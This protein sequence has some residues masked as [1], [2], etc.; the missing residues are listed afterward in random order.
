MSNTNPIG[1]LVNNYLMMMALPLG[2]WFVAEYLLRCA[3]MRNIYLSFVTTPLMVV[4]PIALWYIL[5][6]LR[7]QILDDKI[8]W[9]QAWTFGTQLMFFAGLIEALFI[10]I[11][12][13][14]LFPT[15]LA[16]MQASLIAQYEES[17]ETLR[18]A[19]AF[20]SMIAPMEDA[21][22]VMREAPIASAI[23]T[24][25]TQLSSDIFQGMLLM[26]VIAFIVRRTETFEDIE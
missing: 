10:Y 15:N 8:S 26:S 4:T 22:D 2:I 19:G 16:E 11:Y 21:I 7:R 1:R 3:A 6:R 24:A 9:F 23:E 18:T 25:I 14:F 12:N 17:L 13:E 20:S 5:R